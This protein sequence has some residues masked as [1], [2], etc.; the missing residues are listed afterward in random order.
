MRDR[1]K[2][3]KKIEETAPSQP[4]PLQPAYFEPEPQRQVETVPEP[5]EEVQRAEGL[6]S[7][8]RPDAAGRGPGHGDDRPAR[9]CGGAGE[10]VPAQ[11]AHQAQQRPGALITDRKDES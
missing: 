3:R 6:K 5:E 8:I 10:D 4:A 7:D 1:L 2:R 9:L 11:V